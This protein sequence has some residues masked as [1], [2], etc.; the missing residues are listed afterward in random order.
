M[1]HG[2]SAE[3]CGLALAEVPLAGVLV[4]DGD[5]GGGV[6]GVDAVGDE[7]ERGDGVAGL[8]FV[9]DG[10]DADAVLVDGFSELGL[11]AARLGPWASEALEQLLA[12]VGWGHGVLLGDGAWGLPPAAEEGEQPRGRR[13][14]EHTSAGPVPLR[15]M[16]ARHVLALRFLKRRSRHSLRHWVT[17]SSLRSCQ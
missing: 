16:S 1:V 11:E 4:P 3:S 8:G 12:E 13:C 5:G 7:E 15:I 17:S 6:G 2:V 10:L 14:Q 9:G